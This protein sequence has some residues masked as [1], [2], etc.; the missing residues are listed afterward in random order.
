MLFNEPGAHISLQPEQERAASVYFA[1]LFFKELFHIF[2]K[3]FNKV[4]R[5]PENNIAATSLEFC[6]PV[7]DLIC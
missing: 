3:V 2:T 7:V 1:F 5:L 4:L 6:V